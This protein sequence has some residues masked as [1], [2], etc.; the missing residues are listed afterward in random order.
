VSRMP[1]LEG[2]VQERTIGMAADKEE[3]D[4]EGGEE[5]GVEG[6]PDGWES[7]DED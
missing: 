5:Q 2:E 1:S 7:M 6:Q 3:S 4:D